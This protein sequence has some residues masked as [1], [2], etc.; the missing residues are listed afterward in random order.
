MVSQ[1]ERLEQVK[2]P[3]CSN[4]DLNEFVLVF[5]I[6]LVWKVQRTPLTDR[7]FYVEWHVDG[8]VVVLVTL[9]LEQSLG[10]VVQAYIGLA[11]RDRQINR[12]HLL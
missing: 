4:S 2:V 3:R 9:D 7:A 6:L 11:V 5:F 8:Q 10:Q 1:R 12:Y